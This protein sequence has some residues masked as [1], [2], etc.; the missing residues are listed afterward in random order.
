MKYFIIKDT[1]KAEKPVLGCLMYDEKSKLFHI[2]LLESITEPPFFFSMFTQNGEYTLNSFWSERWVLER[3]VPP[4]RHNIAQILK[5]N[6]MEEYDTFKMLELTRGVSPQDGCCLSK[7]SYEKVPAE[8]KNRLQ[9]KIQ[10]ILPV[11]DYQLMVF[12]ES[13]M[14]KLVDMKK[15]KDAAVSVFTETPERFERVSVEAGGMAVKWNERAV[16]SYSELLKNGITLPMSVD[17]LY[18]FISDRTVNI[19]QAADELNCSRQNIEDLIR[20]NKIRPIRGDA[21]ST[22]LSKN[23]VYQRQFKGKEPAILN[24][25]NV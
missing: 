22:L 6:K 20:R 7:I 13:G 1:D 18:G 5:E 10:E 9:N 12:F 11:E 14:T 3:I 2:E 16:V 17:N 19:A 21:K 8:I 25:E 4:G 24:V 23:Q 15:I